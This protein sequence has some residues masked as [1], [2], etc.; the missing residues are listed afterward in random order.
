MHIEEGSEWQLLNIKKG[1]LAE[2]Y[3]G[4]VYTL[5]HRRPFATY[6]YCEWGLQRDGMSVQKR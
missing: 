5:V 1:S 3:V 2:R 6:E 4:E